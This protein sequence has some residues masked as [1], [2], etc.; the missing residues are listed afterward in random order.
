MSY[1]AIALALIGATGLSFYLSKNINFKSSGK[2]S[3]IIIPFIANM[4]FAFA[5]LG[6]NSLIYLSM[7]IADAA[8]Y[9]NLLTPLTNLY[10]VS[11]WFTSLTIVFY[12]I[13]TVINTIGM[14]FNMAAKKN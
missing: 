8:S 10:T 5:L 9:T 12:S 14:L 13:T 1:D 4:F 6:I 7:Q 3:Q 2:F 11:I